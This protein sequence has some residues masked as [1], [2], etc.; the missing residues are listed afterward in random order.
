MPARKGVL[1]AKA[2]KRQDESECDDGEEKKK[3][4]VGDEAFIYPEPESLLSLRDELFSQLEA[5]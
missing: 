4:L 2:A 3:F 5:G 1:T